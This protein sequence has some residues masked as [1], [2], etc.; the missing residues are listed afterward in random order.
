M[1]ILVTGAAG[2][3]GSALIPALVRA[4]HRVVATDISVEMLEKAGA[5]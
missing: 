5:K 3:L 4:G 2:M 1:L